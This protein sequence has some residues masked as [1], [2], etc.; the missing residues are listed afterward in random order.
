MTRPWIIG[1]G[2]VGVL[3]GACSLVSLDGLAGGG[4]DGGAD[5]GAAPAPGD[6][7]PAS[8][9]ANAADAADAGRADVTDA[10]GPPDADAACV[11]LLLNP[12]F[13][14][15]TDCRPWTNFSTGTPS[16]SGLRACRPCTPGGGAGPINLQTVLVGQTFGPGEVIHFEAWLRAS[17]GALVA[18]PASLF[19]YTNTTDSTSATKL[20][21][22]NAYQRIAVDYVIPLEGGPAQ[23]PGFE[24]LVYGTTDAGGECMLMDD[25]TA[26]RKFDGG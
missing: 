12:G 15:R 5:G 2:A 25:V 16:R 17:D 4:G 1:M 11:N 10:A 20:L 7:G 8:D 6:T 3:G 23:T 19:V 22:S 21:L 9:A 24:F 13:E 26:C 14:E 18:V